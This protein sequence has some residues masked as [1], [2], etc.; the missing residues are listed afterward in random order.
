MSSYSVSLRLLHESGYYDPDVIADDWHMALKSHFRRGGDVHLRA[1][2]LPFLANT[3]GG[4]TW[5]EA[6]RARYAQTF[7]HAWGAKEIGYTL[8]Q[9][10]QSA[11]LDVGL[12][13][14]VA[15][16]NLMAGA[17]WLILFL[18]PQLPLLIH[19]AW[20]REQFDTLPFVALQAAL[21]V[22]TAL[23]LFFW[24]LDLRLRPPRPQP[25]TMGERLREGLN[26]PLV[27]V[28]TAVCVALPVLHAQTRLMLGKPISFRV[29]PKE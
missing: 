2:F 24:A 21:I 11:R 16:D 17:G 4:A 3:T 7:R 5:W 25:W 13:L 28:L 14:R 20:M 23:T 9:M 19:P 27:A 26:L 29:T 6:I 10:R 15:H 18:G 1:I 8:A 22:V 12:V